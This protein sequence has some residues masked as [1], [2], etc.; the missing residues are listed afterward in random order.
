MKYARSPLVRLL[1]FA[2]AMMLGA[3][4]LVPL[5]DRPIPAATQSYS[6]IFADVS[7]LY[8]GDD[9]RLAGV[10]VGKVGSLELLGSRALVRFTLRPDVSIYANTVLAVRF[11]NL[12]GERYLAI[13][14]TGPPTAQL[15]PGSR[16]DIAQTSS[17]ID[18][19]TVFNGLAPVFDT[20][21]PEQADKLTRNMAAFLQGDGA[22]L[23]PLLADIDAISQKVSDRDDVIASLLTHLGEI[24]R[25]LQGRSAEFTTLLTQIKV[26]VDALQSKLTDIDQTLTVGAPTVAKLGALLANLDGKFDAEA[27]GVVAALV[28]LIGQGTLDQA[29]TILETLPLGVDDAR[30][31]LEQLR[32]TIPTACGDPAA[33][34]SIPESITIGDR[35]VRPCP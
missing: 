12:T 3:A 7:G 14:R 31:L 20:L 18:L 22:G 16:I 27:P 35:T 13:E 15:R 24:S 17:P 32:S 26:M 25:T 23:A 33:T 5:L 19:T 4:G 2:A 34:G 11:Q 10:A 29:A 8:E 9:V 1:L 28:R 6:A 21:S 30:K